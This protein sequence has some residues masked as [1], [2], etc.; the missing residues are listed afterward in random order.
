MLKESAPKAIHRRDYA[1][2]AYRTERTALA[3]DLEDGQTTVRS[4]LR[5]LRAPGADA[6][7]PLVLDGQDL[8]LLSVHLDGRRLSGNE[9]Q[10]DAESL[11]IFGLPDAFELEVATRIRPEANTALEGLYK[12]G[13]M[14]CTQ[15]EAEGFRRI[16]YYQDRPDVLSRFT[17][18]ITAA[19]ERFPVLLA[20]GNLVADE[21]RGARRT[22]TW[23]DPF[24]KPSY[25]FALVAGDLACRTDHF[26]TQGGRRVELRIYSEPHN[27]GQCE[28]AMGALQRAMRWDEETF[29]REYDLDI[30]MIVAVEHFN[31]GAMENK[32]LN[33]FN[34]ACVLASPDT[35]VDAA[36]QR[37]EAVIAHEY[38]HNWSG[39]RVTCR[40][41]FQLSLKEGF[42]VFRDAEFT[43]DMHSRTV[44][45][46]EDVNF[47]RTQQFAEDSGPL[48]HSVRPDSYIEISNFYTTTVYEKGAEVVGMTQ[49]LLGRRA[50]AKAP[51]STLSD[52]TGRPSPPRTSWRRWRAPMGPT[53]GSFGCGTRK[54]APRCLT[55]RPLGGTARST[56]TSAKVARRRRGRRTSSPCTF[57]C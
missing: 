22:V 28:Y 19:A 15:C 17:T 49:R 18:S 20:N 11:R 27:I 39:N 53:C 37:V 6:E 26:T 54:P 9:Y 3:F 38:F 8:E 46:I 7:A 33:V 48:A 40:D 57:R 45:R 25:L 47:L 50:S 13:E 23:E 12:S 51:T 36:Y 21:R 55:C 29:G 2:P 42:T 32:G 1:A 44:K 30:Y 31:M 35:A 56:S 34:T 16:T 5:I 41:W 4:R 43:S 24:P 14:Y 52:T 10:V